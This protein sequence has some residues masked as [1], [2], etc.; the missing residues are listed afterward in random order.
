MIKICV[1][2]KEVEERGKEKKK[3]RLKLYTKN[4]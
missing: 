2:K 3:E 4:K 1:Q